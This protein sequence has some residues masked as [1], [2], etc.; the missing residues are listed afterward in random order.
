MSTIINVTEVCVCVSLQKRFN[1]YKYAFP[2]IAQKPP[3]LNLGKV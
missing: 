3:A 1:A 2:G